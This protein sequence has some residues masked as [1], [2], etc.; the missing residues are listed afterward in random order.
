M[1]PTWEPLAQELLEL[2]C[3]EVPFLVRSSVRAAIV[4]AAERDARSHRRRTITRDA[5]IVSTIRIAPDE[6]KDDLRELL[7]REKIS[8]SKFEKYF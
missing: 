8:L 3:A 1:A 7:E 5:M 2:I 4:E 6:V